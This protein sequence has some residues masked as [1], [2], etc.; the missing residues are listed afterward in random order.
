MAR[1]QTFVREYCQACGVCQGS[2][3]FLASHS[4]EYLTPFLFWWTDSASYPLHTR[5][6]NHSRGHL[7]L[8]LLREVFR[9]HGVPEKII[10]ARGAVFAKGF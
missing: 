4:R 10:S 5:S 2:Q 7:A 1:P 3:G 9:H 8:L 6:E